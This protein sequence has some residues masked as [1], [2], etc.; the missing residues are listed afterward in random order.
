MPLHKPAESDGKSQ[1]APEDIEPGKVA[2]NSCPFKSD[3]DDREKKRR[4]VWLRL[5]PEL[6]REGRYKPSYHDFFEQYCIVVVRMEEFL[7]WLEEED[8][9]YKTEGRNGIQWKN[10][11]QVGQYNADWSKWNSMT[12]QMGMSPITDERFKN[13]SPADLK[14]SFDDF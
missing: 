5:I 12:H 1:E 8:W 7:E 2:L 6:I 13:S 4:K 10:Y 14:N 11:P 9:T 3:G